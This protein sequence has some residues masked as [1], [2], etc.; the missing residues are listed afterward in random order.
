MTAQIDKMKVY[1]NIVKREGNSVHATEQYCL[2]FFKLL[3]LMQANCDD[4]ESGQDL[5]DNTQ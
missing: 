5:K 1:E 3:N 2:S 4:T